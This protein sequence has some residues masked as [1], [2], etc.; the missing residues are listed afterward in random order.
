VTTTSLLPAPDRDEEGPEPGSHRG[1]AYNPA[2]DGIRGLAVGAVLLFHGGFSWARGGYLGVST[3]F[4]LSGFLITSLLL[5]EHRRSGRIG[6]T[7]FWARRL[8]RLLPASAVTLV[9]LLASMV[10]VDD[11]WG[12]E[13]PGD[14]VASALQVANWHFLWE[15]RS[16]GELF[17]APSPALHFWS[18]AIEEQFYWVFPLLAAGVL[19]FGRRVL[20]GVLLGLLAGSAVL[21]LIY[22]SSPDTVYYATPIRMGEILVGA[23]LAV[24]ITRR[25][26]PA[27][28]RAAGFAALSGAGSS[29]AGTAAL[30]VSVWA[31]VNVEQSSEVLSR[32]GLLVYAVASG[33]LVLA[34]CGTGPL[35][36]V[37][38]FEPLRLLGLVSY[39]VYL[40]HWPLFLVLTPQ[41][42]DDWFGW[43]PDGWPLFLAR[44]APT[45]VIA[46]ASYFLLE[47]PI[48]RGRFLWS[49]DEPAPERAAKPAPLSGAASRLPWAPLVAFGSIAAVVTAALVVPDSAAAPQVD[50]FEQATEQLA[51]LDDEDLAAAEEALAERRAA[52]PEEAVDVMFF[53]DSAAL[54]VAAGVGE[55]GLQSKELLLVGDGTTTQVGCGIG[56]DGER[57]QFGSSS[58]IPPT[59]PRWDR[60][61]APEID[62]RPDT[63]VGV[64]LT[65]SWD[66]MDR[67]L[68]GDD[69]WRGLGDPVYDDYMRAEIAGATDVLL[70]KGLTVVW[71]TTPPL[72]FGRAM[73]PRPEPDP[74]DARRRIDRLNELIG[75]VVADRPGAAVVDF[76]GR[77]AAMSQA[78]NDRLRPD[79]VHVDFAVSL[80]VAG[81][82][83][84]EILAA[85]EDAAQDA[86][87]ARD[88]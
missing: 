52:M 3:F 31:W 70:A 33:A 5:A 68:P 64:I 50:Q 32:G 4:T 56:R 86:Q 19:R 17:A 57:R 42:L 51:G 47:Q 22:R 87:D 88:G 60:D 18:L 15:D 29:L 83:A 36:R 75:E 13:L 66:V 69:R 2:L 9:A 12:P 67:R 63:Q 82:L 65:G 23:L 78:E 8:R 73:V 85:V 55:W 26:E 49:H 77:F 74:A 21:T 11:L 48:R 72:D 44:L 10:L 20:A 81:W 41:R 54:T 28:E 6:L 53:G 38:A 30:A 24:W 79:G 84:P 25:P 43:R 62:E 16:Y 61:W 35:R 59:C 1:L 14:V 71:L 40:F 46:T 34:A 76:G 58:V 27:P 7:A 37:L 45:L 80:E 39:G